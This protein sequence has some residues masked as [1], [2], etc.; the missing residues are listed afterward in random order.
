[1]K[2]M[3]VCGVYL[4]AGQSRRMGENKLA[5][6][7]RKSTVGSMAFQAALLSKLEHIIVVTKENDCL[8]W[9]DP[10]FFQK[11][12]NE[13]WSLARCQDVVLG[14]AHSLKCGLHAAQKRHPNGIMVLLADQ[15]FLH[16][17]LINDLIILGEQFQKKKDMNEITYVAASFQGVP[18]PPILF[19]QQAFPFLLE[20]KGDEG[21]RQLFQKSILKGKLL[22]LSDERIFFD[23][24]T[25]EDYESVANETI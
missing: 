25:K 13:K 12:L 19:L 16:V 15:P 22:E 1:M 3:Q 21:A 23:L 24:D 9:M 6:P 10:S 20:L 7:L 11:P 8:S 17:K 5:L 14:Q 2:E 4:A 18:R